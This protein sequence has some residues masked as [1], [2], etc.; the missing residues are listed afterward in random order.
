[1]VRYRVFPDLVV[2]RER[3]GLEGPSCSY[4][5]NPRGG[6][7]LILGKNGASRDDVDDMA[8]VLGLRAVRTV[9]VRHY[10]QSVQYVCAIAVFAS[11]SVV[12]ARYP[13]S[14][15]ARRMSIICIRGINVG[16]TV[17][18]VRPLGYLAVYCV[19]CP[20]AD[21]RLFVCGGALQRTTWRET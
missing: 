12:G 8:V 1:M 21:E 5:G 4:K 19:K 16:H 14:E 13:W 17:R 3:S 10:V 20:S 6:N 2:L 11:V 18:Q 7:F 15:L 9:R